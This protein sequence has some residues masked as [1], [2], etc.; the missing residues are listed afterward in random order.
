MNVLT[1][2][3]SGFRRQV[4]L[5]CKQFVKGF[6]FCVAQS[7]RYFGDQMRQDEMSRACSMD[8]KQEKLEQG[9]DEKT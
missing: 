9:F 1:E 5:W 8:E 3:L 6:L 4:H 2:S 7:I